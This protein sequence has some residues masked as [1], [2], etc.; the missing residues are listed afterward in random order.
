MEKSIHTMHNKQRT[1][2]SRFDHVEN[3][4]NYHEVLTKNQQWK[5]S[6][7]RPSDDYWEEIWDE[8]TDDEAENFLEQIEHET[9]EMRFPT[10]NGYN[11]ALNADLPY[12][13]ELL[14]HWTEF[15][16]A[17]EQYKHRLKCLPDN[18]KSM[19]SLCGM[20]LPNEVMDLLSNALKSTHFNQFV[21]QN[22]DSGGL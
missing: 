16:K 14:P 12:N 7:P 1:M 17:L 13:E 3:K 8:V 15:A 2:I 6:A 5:Y 21:L 20:E 19:F 11:I 10:D 18:E 9:K 4:L 22:N